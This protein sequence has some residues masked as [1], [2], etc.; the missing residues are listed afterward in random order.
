MCDAW[1][2]V[3][4]FEL[5]LDYIVVFLELKHTKKVKLIDFPL[6]LDKRTKAITQEEKRG[7][8]R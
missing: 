5:T 4:N 8:V 6:V 7:A 2:W 1:Y 3:L